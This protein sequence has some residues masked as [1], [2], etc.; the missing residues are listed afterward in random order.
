MIQETCSVFMTKNEEE[1]SQF[2]EGKNH[3]IL[4]RE[5]IEMYANDKN[6]SFLR[7]MVTCSTAGYTHNIKKLGYDGGSTEKPIEVKPQNIKSTGKI[8]LNASGNFTDFTWRKFKKCGEDNVTML[9]SGFIDGKLMFIIEFPFNDPIFKNH[10]QSKLQKFLPKGDEINRY[11]RS[12]NWSFIH[13][14]KSIIRYRSK[15]LKDFKRN[16]SKKLFN[17]LENGEVDNVK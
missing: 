7:E 12:C 2:L 14:E 5:L 9:M 1:F 11:I 13:F 6:S 10:L 4:L 16:F 3:A 17:F 15:K 8:K